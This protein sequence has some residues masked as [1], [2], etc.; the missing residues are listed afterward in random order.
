MADRPR[1]PISDLALPTKS[2]DNAHA[3]L[4]SGR[5]TQGP[6]VAEVEAAISRRIPGTPHVVCCSTGTAALHM[7]LVAAN[8]GS[9]PLPVVVVP[10]LT[11]VAT[12]NAAR[13]VGARVLVAD[14]DPWSWV[15]TGSTLRAAIDTYPRCDNR[16]NITAVI[17]V[18]LYDAMCDVGPGMVPELS[19]TH[20]IVDAAHMAPIIE[21]PPHVTA[22]TH[23]FYASKIIGCGEGG[24]VITD[25][26]TVA[27]TVRRY[28]GQGVAVAGSYDHQSVGNNYRMGEVQAALLGGQLPYIDAILAHRRLLIDAYKRLFAPTSIITQRG[29]PAHGWMMAVVLPE[30]VDVP[31]V[32]G[33]LNDTYNIETR[34]FFTPMNS[35]PLSTIGPPTPIADQLYARG[36]CLPVHTGMGVPDVEYIVDSLVSVLEGL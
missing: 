35:L 24:A 16:H 22:M 14:V 28:R 27:D 1:I 4:A 9:G 30:G 32:R 13:Y 2:I 12:A 29:T 33:Q 20:F 34:R 21:P 8:A 6:V 19:S 18:H 26:T 7:A 31:A 3:V 36:L 11:Y 23:S 15:M 10:A 5:L 17:A 25:G